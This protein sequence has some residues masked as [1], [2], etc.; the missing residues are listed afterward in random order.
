MINSSTDNIDI[1]LDKHPD[2]NDQ[3]YL[4]RLDQAIR[5][6]YYTNWNEITPKVNEVLFGA[7]EDQY[8][9]ESAFR[10]ECASARRF[11][12]AGVFAT[13]D[14]ETIK[15]LRD[16]Q[17]RLYIAR[18]Q[19][20]DQRRE[21]NKL[22]VQD[23]RADN[24]TERL[25]EVAN[26]MNKD[27]P[28]LGTPVLS[29]S[30]EKEALLV[31]TDWHYGM[32]TD[33][34]WN[35]YNVEICKARVKETV[36][37]TIEYLKIFEINKLHVFQLGDMISGAIH[38]SCRVASEENS[39]DQLIHVSELLAEVLEEL[40]RYCN[41]VNFYSCYGNHARVVAKKDE[42][43]HAENLERMIPFWLRQRLQNNYKVHVIDSEY[44]EFTVLNILG[45]N[46][47]GVHGDL[48]NIREAAT[49]F[50]TLFTRKFGKQIDLIVSGDKHHLEEFDRMGIPAMIVPSLCGCDEYANNKR[51]YSSAGQTLMIFN[52]EEGR[53][54]T[55]NIMFK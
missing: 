32:I 53:E 42:A 29:H 45:Y 48:D 15:Q 46:V 30:S 27:I 23:A 14:N 47:C 28:L 25:I 24:L 41:E 6:G 51:L 4:W 49:T 16:E 2:E 26:Q 55:R 5:A 19:L 52:K 21:Y 40:S 50:N 3:Q 22:L 37:K 12:E 7:D 35:T 33:N 18:R 43:I 38:V 10:K 8:K 34:I 13:N 31:L 20:A 17:D 39:V 1:S 54:C 44:K 9:G 36:E 11:F